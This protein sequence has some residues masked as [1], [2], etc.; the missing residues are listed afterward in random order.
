MPRFC[1]DADL[2]EFWLN[3]EN[4]M[5]SSAG[6]VPSVGITPMPETLSDKTWDILLGRI[7]ERRCTPFLGAGACFGSLPLG[8]EIAQK[9][10]ADHG[11]P[12]TNPNNL[13]EVAQFLAIKYDPLFPKEQ[14][15]QQFAGV[16]GPD[17]SAA[18]EPHAILA[19]LPLPVY[20]TTN[21][22]DFMVQA[23][24]RRHRDPRRELCRWNESLEGEESVFDTDF[25]PTPANPVVYH[26]HGHT[27]PESLVLTEDDYLSFLANIARNAKLLPMPIQKALD[28]STCLFIGYRLADWNFR[29]L[30]QGL[31]PRLKL[32]NIAI[33]KPSDDSD[34]AREQREYLNKYYASMD[35]QVYWGTARQFAGE[36][37]ERWAKCQ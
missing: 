27:I 36:L 9:W 31:R 28:R 1:R 3:G 12:F 18:D 4:V 21:Y 30:F 20:M 26:L 6:L 37:R 7:K 34:R 13:I 11:Y 33:L 17:F 15:L 24:K 22:D 16:K 32:L 29:V 8:A 25:V 14:I 2:K 19:D 5:A 35:L 10:A 23:L